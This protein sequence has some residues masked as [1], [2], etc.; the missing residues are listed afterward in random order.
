MSEIS[1]KSITGITSITTPAG[2]DNQLTLH[3]NNTTEAV[4][5]DTAGNVHVNNQLSIA[6]VS[7]FS[8]DVKFVGATSGRDVQWDKSA[9]YLR[10]KDNAFAT[11]GN[12]DDLFIYHDGNHSQI[13]DVGTG[14]LIL[15]GT[16]LYLTDGSGSEYFLQCIANNQVDLYF[17]NSIKL[18]TTSAGITVTGSATASTFTATNNV[19]AGGNISLTS[20]TGKLYIGASQD[21]HIFHNGS[22]SYIQD[23]GTGALLIGSGNTSGAGVYIRGKHGEESIIA[24]SNGGVDLYYDNVK[25]FETIS[26]GI[27]VTGDLTLTDT[28]TDS[29][30]G[31]ELKLYRNS[32]SPADADYLGQ[33]KFAGESDTG[34]ERNYAKIT[35]KILDASNGTEDGII[36]FAHIKAG[37]QN[38]SARFRS[39]SLQLLNGTS[40]TVAGTSTFTGDVDISDSIV[41]TGDT[42]TKIRFPSNDQ[43]SFETGGSE[44]GRFDNDG[45]FL[46]GT[47]GHGN[48]GAGARHLV[49]SG[50]SNQGLTINSTNTSGIYRDCNIYFGY[51]T[52]TNDMAKGQLTYS[53]NGDYLHMSVG[54]TAYTLAKSFRLNSD[55]TVR[56]DS[57]HTNAN[58]QSLVIKS[59][60]ARALN[61]NNG[62]VFRDAND[63]TQAVINV[64][65]KSTSDATSDLVF[66]TSSGQVVNTLQGIP[67]RM[68]ITSDG[69]VTRPYQ[70]AFFAHCNIGDHDLAGGDKFQ[71]NVLT[72]SGKAAVNST[73][74]TFGGTAVFNT[75]TNT[76]T[77]PVAGL[78]HFTVSVYFRRTGDPLTS[79]VPRVNNTEVL[80]GNN[81]LFFVSSNDIT[82][83]N[84]QCGSLTLQLAAND[85]VTVHR[86]T[87]NSSV[88]RF[89]GP[90]SH[91]CG[92]LI[93]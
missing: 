77:A 63:H 68:R 80:N 6:G 59:H 20:D 36:E 24:N 40:L 64:P 45:N 79:L 56:F 89:Y 51:G 43:I 92:H 50:P 85:A 53:G 12:S 32:S 66:R 52:S 90:H 73:H 9:N 71:F 88:T 69:Y 42:D 61:D 46:I 4:K 41:H 13:R 81:T 11:F 8:E 70:V 62:I 93:G 76:F 55:G 27:S 91:F 38:I 87:G 16:H 60:K 15:G 78:Y 29:S 7:T 86:R 65:K 57:T 21:L 74:H 33:I 84:Q 23:N 75:S 19:S 47:T 2:V 82:D 1:L 3:N 10:F 83:G 5:V 25:K 54:N 26:T 22:N 72:S 18:S 34:V 14:H 30:A 35:G 28:A 48:A 49:I 44:R 37:S 17:N 31:P 39:D 67:E 58:S